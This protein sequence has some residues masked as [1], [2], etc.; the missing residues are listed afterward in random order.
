MQ[1]ERVPFDVITGKRVY[2]NMLVRAIEVTTDKTSEN[3]LNCTLTLREVIM[4]QTQSV[5][6]ADKSICRMA[7]AHRRCKIPGRNPLH[8]Q[9]NPCLSQLGGSVTSALGDDMQFN[10]IPLSPD[11]QQFRVLLGNTT[12]TL[13]I[14]WRDAAGWI[15]DVMDSGGAALLSGVPLLTGV[16]LLRQY[17]QLGIDG[18]LVV[19][20]DKGAPDEPPKPISAHTATSFSFRSRNVS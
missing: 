20:T 1:L 19:A 18:A 13:R 10:E 17:P 11:N 2:T 6:V 16:N 15:M 12:Y 3:V 5:S 7:S 4:S 14:I 8:R 9:T